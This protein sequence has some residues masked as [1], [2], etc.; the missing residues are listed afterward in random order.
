MNAR[1]VA[2]PG[3]IR[4]L[5]DA[6][7][8]AKRGDCAGVTVIEYAREGGWNTTSAGNVMRL[9]AMGLVAA[10]V[11]SS[12]FL[13]SVETDRSTMPHIDRRS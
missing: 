13:R 12:Q 11:L 1:A 9:P 3:V 2:T 6:L 7:A 8:R 5:E 10:Q 4:V